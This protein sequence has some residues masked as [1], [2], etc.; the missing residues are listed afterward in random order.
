MYECLLGGCLDLHSCFS[1]KMTHTQGHF[2]YILDSSN[3]SS[4]TFWTS[5]FSCS[6]RSNWIGNS[7]ASWTDKQSS[8]FS[9]AKATAR[10]M[11]VKATVISCKNTTHKLWNPTELVICKWWIELIDKREYQKLQMK[12]ST[13]LLAVTVSM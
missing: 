11:T 10:A 5:K 6:S 12:P 8:H 3:S 2:I 7:N 13:A 4:I 1:R 9:T